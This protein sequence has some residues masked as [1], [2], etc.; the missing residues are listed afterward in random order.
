MP[1]AEK[2][3]A[4]LIDADNAPAARIDVILNEVARY[5]VANVRRAYG[6]WKNPH[7]KNWEA[8]LLEHAIRPMQQFA[9]SKGKNASDMAMVIDAMDLLHTRDPDGFAIVSSDAD[10]TPLVM[11]LR[12]VGVEVYGFG[13]KKTPQAFVN[14]CSKFIYVEALDVVSEPVAGPEVKE[15]NA[16]DLRGNTKLVRTLRSAVQNASGDDDWAHLGR[17][18]NQLVNKGAFDPRNY[19]YPKLRNLIEDIGLFEVKHENNAVWVREKSRGTDSRG[20]DSRGT[21]RVP[22]K[23]G[24]AGAGRA[25]ATKVVAKPVKTSPAKKSTSKTTKKTEAVKAPVVPTFSSE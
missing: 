18:G 15:K 17:I 16:K 3:I 20:T 14:A 13:E 25:A 22:P 6:D 11:H 1:D 10:F 8:E 4:L 19:G 2:H 5:G 23:V 9:Y 7:L 12:D 21:D 24:V